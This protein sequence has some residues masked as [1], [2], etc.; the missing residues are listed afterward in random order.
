[1]S[2]NSG[3]NEVGYSPL[4]HS[5]RKKFG[6]A[7]STGPPRALHATWVAPPDYN[8]NVSYFIVTT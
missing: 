2:R 3:I 8:D 1:M 6:V 4:P 5:S 7:M